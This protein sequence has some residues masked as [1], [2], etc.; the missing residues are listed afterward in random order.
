MD[1]AI[2]SGTVHGGGVFIQFWDKG[3]KGMPAHFGKVGDIGTN[4]LEIAKDCPA[5]LV[6]VILSAFHE[7]KNAGT[8]MKPTH[9]LEWRLGAAWFEKVDSGAV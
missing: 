4:Q 8:I 9:T 5:D 6:P 2:V 3:V 1:I 7:W